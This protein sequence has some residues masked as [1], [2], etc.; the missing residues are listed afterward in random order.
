[1]D[2]FDLIIILVYNIDMRII[3]GKFKGTN[4]LEFDYDN[5]RPTIDRVKEG[6]FNK[7]Q[8]NIDGANVLD[9]FAGTG[10]ISLEFLSRGATNVT[11]CDNNPNSI[12]LI[13]QNFKKCRLEPKL[14]E[15]DYKKILKNLQGQKFDIIF[16]DPPYDTDYGEVALNLI[17]KYGL[18]NDDGVVI[19]EHHLGMSYVLPNSFEILD[20]KKYGTVGVSFIGCRHESN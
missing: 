18:L 1:M 13:R 3:A 14:I 4:L 8:F 5:I 15:G 19:Y 11:L 17:E 16:L 9:L 6:I 20:E 7:I 12:K 10:N 2:V